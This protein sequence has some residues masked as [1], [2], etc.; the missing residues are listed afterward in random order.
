MICSAMETDLSP[1]QTAF[2]CQRYTSMAPD[3]NSNTGSL[4]RALR[5]VITGNRSGGAELTVRPYASPVRL[6]ADAYRPSLSAPPRT[7][8]RRT[9]R[10][11]GEGGRAPQ[12]RS[13]SAH[14]FRSRVIGPRHPSRLGGHGP[15]HMNCLAWVHGVHVGP[16]F[17]AGRL[18][19][20]GPCARSGPRTAGVHDG[21][22]TLRR[23]AA[24]ISIAGSALTVRRPEP[25]P[26]SEGGSPH[27]QHPRIARITLAY[28]HLTVSD[29]DGMRDRTGASGMPVIM[30]S[31][32]APWIPSFVAIRRS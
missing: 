27:H 24:T 5:C 1:E 25:C 15:L 4:A 9:R 6:D 10:P 16:A 8:P 12:G 28:R 3:D 26:K 11:P 21:I 31:E 18:P 23:V 17:R 29:D 20:S 2:G 19:A 30:S 13:T 7:R 32:H 22:D 14:A